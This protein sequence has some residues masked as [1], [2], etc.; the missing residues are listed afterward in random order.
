[1]YVY[2]RKTQRFVARKPS[3]IHIIKW[4]KKNCDIGSIANWRQ[5]FEWCTFDFAW[6]FLD[7]NN[8][9]VMSGS[10]QWSL[11]LPR[12]HTQSSRVVLNSAGS[13][14]KRAW[15]TGPWALI[16]IANNTEILVLLIIIA[17]YT[18][19]L[20]STKYISNYVANFSA[21]FLFCENHSIVKPNSGALLNQWSFFSLQCG[22]KWSYALA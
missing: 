20:L 10:G 7:G 5:I 18:V 16:T 8:V 14:R 3:K 15:A 6:L 21:S 17:K 12:F 9:I 22:S 2:Y 19:I 1:M 13:P 4:K 11:S